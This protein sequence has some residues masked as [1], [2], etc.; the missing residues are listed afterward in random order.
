[1]TGGVLVDVYWCF[2]AGANPE[3]RMRHQS[4]QQ[5]DGEK[6]FFSIMEA[7]LLSTWQRKVK[8]NVASTAFGDAIHSGPCGH[9]APRENAAKV[10]VAY[11]VEV[12]LS[13]PSPHEP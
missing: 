9:K 2:M 1:M 10:N 7:I 13:T 6:L 4:I 5:F 12:G 8:G 3:Q 11:M